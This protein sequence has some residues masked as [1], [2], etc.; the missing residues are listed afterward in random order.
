M[1]R[2]IEMAQEYADIIPPETQAALQNA[3]ER[4]SLAE[5]E[6]L[7]DALAAQFLREL[8]ASQFL[9]ELLALDD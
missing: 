7:M 8:L 3:I 9:R 2:I 6:A 4:G 1:E 5:A